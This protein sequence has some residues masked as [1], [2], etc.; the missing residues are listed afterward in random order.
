MALRST[1]CDCAGLGSAQGL[2]RFERFPPDA[3]IR[4]D[5]DNAKRGQQPVIPKRSIRP[6]MG[7]SRLDYCG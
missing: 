2:G 5:N 1:R 7:L 4:K 3:V 6:A